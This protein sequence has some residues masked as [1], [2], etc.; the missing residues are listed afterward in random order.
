MELIHT[1][2]IKFE[3]LQLEQYDLIFAVLGYQP[4][5]TYLARHFEDTNAEKILFDLDCPDFIEDLEKNENIFSKLGFKKIE[6]LKNNIDT[7]ADILKSKTA[8][9]AR[10][11][12]NILVDYSCMP[13][14][15]IAALIDYFN[16]NDFSFQKANVFFSYT[17]ANYYPAE[18]KVDVHYLGPILGS[19]DI[20]KDKKSVSV[21]AGMENCPKLSSKLISKLKPENIYAFIPETPAIQDYTASVTEVNQGFLKQLNHK[22]ILSY[23]PDNPEEINSILT[24]LCLDLRIHSK[25]VILPHGPKPFGL[26]SMLLAT[27]Y[28]DIVLW[29]TVSERKPIGMEG[30]PIDIPIILKTIFTDDDDPDSFYN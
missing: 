25:V 4:R 16:S 27:R 1:C 19:E 5:C 21:I 28:P 30:E 14:K 3:E 7:I 20:I 22:N 23:S 9:H 2:Q 17:P 6:C 13:K 8:R 18:T 11:N 15:W 29:D 26:I 10:E 12:F 24:S